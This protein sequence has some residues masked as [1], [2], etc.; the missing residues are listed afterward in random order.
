V[1]LGVGGY[2]SVARA[3][4]RVNELELNEAEAEEMQ[5]CLEE[6]QTK[7]QWGNAMVDALDSQF[8]MSIRIASLENVKSCV[9][10]IRPF[11]IGRYPATATENG[12][13]GAKMLPKARWSAVLFA[14]S[15]SDME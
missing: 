12:R 3:H 14:R 10:R 15:C 9:S 11:L 5:A 8:P 2:G 1:G 6:R 13:T 7:A 4:A